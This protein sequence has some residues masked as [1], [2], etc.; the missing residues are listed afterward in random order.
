MKISV[1]EK[2]TIFDM[3]CGTEHVF[4]VV[5]DPSGKMGVM[6]KANYVE[7]TGRGNL[8]FSARSLFTDACPFRQQYGAHTYRARD[9]SNASEVKAY[10]LD[11][12][13]Q[14]TKSGNPILHNGRVLLPSYA[15]YEEVLIKLDLQMGRV[16]NL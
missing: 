4:F 11:R 12:W 8:F 14:F 1:A 7:Q 16:N 5:D 3:L 6:F 15:T 13:M 9:L 2:A 10:C